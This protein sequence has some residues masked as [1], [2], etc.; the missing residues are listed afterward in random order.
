MKN[1]DLLISIITPYYKTLE[2]TEQL[3]KVLE[4]QL[5]DNVEWI[6][7]D[8]GCEEKELDKYKAKVIHLSNN[9]GCAGIPRNHGLDI[10]KGKY[11]TF[12]DSDDLVVDNFISRI[13]EEIKTEKDYYL[14]SWKSK[15]TGLVDVSNGRPN[16]NCSVW[17]IVYKKDLIGNNRFND[18]KMAEDYVFNQN[19]LSGERGII[20][21][22]LYIYNTENPSITR[23]GK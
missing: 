21:D 22:C 2:Y 14:M 23:G 4:P 20:K 7:I 1:E 6:I 8:D 5:T 16:W 12:V 9:S 10:A 18:L 19:V 11:I 3:R 17:G 13:L 15:Q